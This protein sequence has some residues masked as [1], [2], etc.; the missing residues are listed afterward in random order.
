MK[1][2]IAKVLYFF[3]FKPTYSQGLHGGTT[4]GY[5]TLDPNGYFEYPLYLDLD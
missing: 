4:C 5:G 3:G 1:E 2:K